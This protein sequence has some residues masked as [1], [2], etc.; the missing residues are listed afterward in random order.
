MPT[1]RQNRPSI[2]KTWRYSTCLMKLAEFP[3]IQSMSVREKLELVD[4][5]WKSASPEAE[6]MEVSA[7]EKQLLNERWAEFLSAPEKA[8]TIEEFNQ[9]VAQL[10][11]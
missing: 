10:R 11:A 4:E 8:L 5:I 9:Q 1:H 3:Q 6:V 7:E 2:R